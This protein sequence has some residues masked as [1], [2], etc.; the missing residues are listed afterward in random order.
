[1]DLSQLIFD[2]TSII[3]D[4]KIS[5]LKFDKTV[6]A[7]IFSIDNLDA[8]EY[9]VRYGGNIFTAYS[10]D[11]NKIY[12]V[13]EK[14]F[15][16]IPEGDFSKRKVINGKSTNSSLSAQDKTELQNT[17]TPVGPTWDKI[18]TCGSQDWKKSYE[19]SI[20]SSKELDILNFGEEECANK[21]SYD[22][23]FKLYASKYSVFRIK[24][25]FQT[26]FLD[27]KTKGNY[28]LKIYLKANK[29]D[30]NGQSIAQDLIYTLDLS[31]FNGD[32][33]NFN[34][35]A[36]QELLIKVQNDYLQGLERIV[37]F[38]N[39]F[40]H[41]TQENEYIR[42]KD[43]ELQFVEI[44]DLSKYIYYLQI[45]APNGT[46]FTETDR[47]LKLQASLYYNGRSALNKSNSEVRWF[48]KNATIEIGDKNYDKNAG[49]GWEF[50]KK[51]PTDLFNEITIN[52]PYDSVNKVFLSIPN[53]EYKVVVVYNKE[54][55][56]DKEI[57]IGTI[58]T[59]KIIIE[60]N[61]T[62][63]GIE[64]SL[65]YDVDGVWY[66]KTPDGNYVYTGE[67]KSIVVT[68][69]LNYA[70][71]DFYCMVFNG[72]KEILIIKEDGSVEKQ[73]VRFSFGRKIEESI[74]SV[75]NFNNLAEGQYT[76]W[77]SNFI[78]GVPQ[79]RISSSLNKQDV[80]VVYEGEDA[81]R[82][83]A[84]GD[85]T[86]EDSERE[87]TISCSIS[88]VD[89][90]GSAY[91]IEWLDNSG[92][93]IK[94]T[95]TI[96]KNSMLD[97]V[98]VD[99]SNKIHFSIKQKFNIGY[100]NNTVILKITTVDNK[101]YEFPKE[102]LFVK[103]GDQGTNGTTYI[104]AIRPCDTINNDN[105]FSG[106][107]GVSL[108]NDSFSCV[109]N[110]NTLKAYVYKDGERIDN[111]SN[112]KIEY[113]WYIAKD[114]DEKGEYTD[115]K[116]NDQTNV[117][118]APIVN[119]PSKINFSQFKFDAQWYYVKAQ[120]TITDNGKKTI[121]Y[122]KYP[123]NVIKN[124]S[125][126]YLN[127]IET[128][129]PGYIKYT[130]SGINP[131]FYN[132]KIIFKYNGIDYSNV[133]YGVNNDGETEPPVKTKKVETKDENGKIIDTSYYLSPAPTLFVDNTTEPY[134]A[135]AI[136]F[137]QDN[138]EYHH[139]IVIYLDTYGNEAI[140]GWDG[141]SLELNEEGGYILAPQIGAG[142]KDSNNTFTGVVMG[143][144]SGQDKVGLYG[145]QKGVNTF[146]LMENGDAYFGKNKEIFLE[147]SGKEGTITGGKN[148]GELDYMELNLINSKGSQ[149]KAI[150]VTN[151]GTDSFYV[152]YDGYLYA[153]NV[154][155]EGDIYANYI[156]ADTSGTI[157]GWSID[158]ESLSGGGTILNKNGTI[159]C[160]NLIANTTGNI[161]GW[162]ISSSG[163]TAQNG[164]I[165]L[166]T[167][168]D[169]TMKG[170]ITLGPSG[171][172]TVDSSG[173]Q[174][175]SGSAEIIVKKNGALA[176]N[177]PGI[178]MGTGG[179]TFY[180]VSGKIQFDCDADNQTGIYARFA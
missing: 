94:Q 98:W 138:M 62:P 66:R 166:Y 164:S 156:K 61:T 21:S 45:K 93:L 109:K 80:I 69:Y 83:D 47:E 23:L 108:Q 67:G 18:Y 99:D 17:I 78:Y 163:L 112:Y 145:Y 5:E 158:S 128:N 160:R 2:S 146:G 165:G 152:R 24:A 46:Y 41:N 126:D 118:V 72:I 92:T 157:G 90:V 43:I 96:L 129:L 115:W 77:D 44:E 134:C 178:S 180:L 148:Q 141:Q 30:E 29:F 162:T 52:Q 116:K 142:K 89:G 174:L 71:I 169:L 161:A 55:I 133:L 84:N 127:D 9:K 95:K 6:D 110:I 119:S 75:D 36:E 97:S 60:Q 32:P 139:S 103:D 101:V 170:T 58:D 106:I 42:V 34:T 179:N 53:E 20:E 91:K 135:G 76:N 121:L 172:L 54:V 171:E 117:L 63:N 28:G 14:V 100:N 86:I 159:T 12:S 136:V 3:M 33:Y 57:E 56:M 124:T 149:T 140:N 105:K 167:S 48:R 64:L 113:E 154:R 16:Q 25:K 176:I 175:S 87:R 153:N 13:G 27:S 4:K 85:I 131:S 7:Q 114:K 137:K 130:S 144:D 50:I 107:W 22:N 10:D 68:D 15:V 1:M 65:N 26:Q 35:W 74:Q 111:Q 155:V 151:S 173:L 31:S 168:G 73:T 88:W 40:E 39:N 123:I 38:E 147:G 79:H 125:A 51:Q 49:V 11:L 37:F 177:G 102:I 120:I 104:S 150:K 132:D 70:Y 143:Q 8:G 19:L 82:Y 122:P 59:D 81:F